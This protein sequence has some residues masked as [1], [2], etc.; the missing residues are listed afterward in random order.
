MLMEI[1]IIFSN[2]DMSHIEPAVEWWNRE[3]YKYGAKSN[4][5]RDFM[6]NPDNYVLEPLSSNRSRGGSTRDRYRPPL[7]QSSDN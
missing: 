6:N 7:R 2:T 3:G 4:E 1:G 5:A